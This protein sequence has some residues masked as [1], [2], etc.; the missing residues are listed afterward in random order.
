MH[1]LRVFLLYSPLL[2]TN[3]ISFADSQDDFY[4]D[5]R[6]REEIKNKFRPPPNPF[7]DTYYDK[8]YYQT[9]AQRPIY[10]VNITNVFIL[11]ITRVQ[12]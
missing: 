2:L 6:F 3:L 10:N 12:L 9:G 4:I 8:S 7:F 5:Q 1:A 11:S